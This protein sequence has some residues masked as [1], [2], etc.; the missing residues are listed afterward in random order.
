MCDGVN[1]KTEKSRF[2][3]R[4][5]NNGF[6]R[7]TIH[8]FYRFRSTFAFVIGSTIASSKIVSSTQNGVYSMFIYTMLI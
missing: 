4:D 7:G 8:S 3:K 1:G 2:D 6:A 5:K